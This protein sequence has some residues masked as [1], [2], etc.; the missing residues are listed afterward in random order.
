VQL[1]GL[2]GLPADRIDVIIRYA[3]CSE[4]CGNS[5]QADLHKAMSIMHI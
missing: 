1:I 5:D 3:A 4:A 2:H